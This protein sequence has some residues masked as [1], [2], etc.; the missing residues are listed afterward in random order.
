MRNKLNYFL[1]QFLLTN[2]I[3][4]FQGVTGS[5]LSGVGLLPIPVPVPVPS[6]GII[7][8]SNDKNSDVEVSK[9]ELP[10]LKGLKVDP[11]SLKDIVDFVPGWG[12]F[13]LGAEVYKIIFTLQNKKGNYVEHILKPEDLRTFEVSNWDPT[14]KTILV[15]HGYTEDGSNS[16]L[17]ATKK[18]ISAYAQAQ[19]PE[20]LIFVDWHELSRQLIYFRSANNTEKVGLRVAELL[21]FLRNSNYVQNLQDVH[22]VGFSLG[23]HCSGI[24]GHFAGE[25]LKEQ[26]GRITGLD[27]AGPGFKNAPLEM[28]LDPTDAT[29]VDVIHTNAGDLL[30][31]FG[32]THISGHVDFWPNGGSHQ[33]GCTLKVIGELVG[34]CSHLKAPEYF[35]NTILK[36]K[37]YEACPCDNYGNF[38]RGSCACATKVRM[39]EYIDESVRGEYYLSIPL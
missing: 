2:L 26:I 4:Q 7:G 18:I 1:L 20:N 8:S 36:A 32:T 19:R 23:A 15:I 30:T 6:L 28:R 11:L 34:V 38:L 39:G 35:I 31:T 5:V 29:F 24:A 3:F 33:P 17:S 12:I 37:D 16:P 22:I 25:F 9:F 27:P 21:I 14:Q 13:N 10:F